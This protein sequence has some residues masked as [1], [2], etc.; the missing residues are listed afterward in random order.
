MGSIVPH[1][2]VDG[3]GKE[4][5]MFRAHVRRKGFASKSKIFPTRSDAKKWLRDNEAV[6][7]LNKAG[8][9][10]T[11]KQ[12]IDDFANVGNKAWARMSQLDF[13][14]E[15]LGTTRARD[16]T[17]VEINGALLTLQTTAALTTA[18]KLH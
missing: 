1:K 15:Q 6:V 8:S 5:V 17:H 7:T 2:K 9:G 12:L 4:L 3:S 11:L 18:P 14:S 16:V 13:W 10:K